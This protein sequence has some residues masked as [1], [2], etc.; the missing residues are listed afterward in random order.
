LCLG[1]AQGKREITRVY[2]FGSRVWGGSHTN[3]DLDVLI[4]A[5][6]G[7]VMDS[8]EKWGVELSSLLGVVVDVNDHFTADPTLADKIRASG[9]LVFSRH[10]SDVHFQFED[11]LPPFDPDKY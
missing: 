9:A 5:Q 6:P 8:G 7:A 4:V 3:S 1:W 2:F 11:E 10:G